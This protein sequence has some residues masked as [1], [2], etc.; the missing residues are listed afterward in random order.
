MALDWIPRDNVLKSHQIFGDEHFGT[1]P[2]CTMFEKKPLVNPDT[3]EVVDG[4]LQ[5]R[6]IDYGQLQTLNDMK[7][8]LLGWVYDVNF[9]PTLKRIK[10]RRILE[11]LIDF[12]PEDV[13]IGRVR[14]K[15]LG[16][17]DFRIARQASE[18]E[19]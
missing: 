1:E 5:G 17:V 8:C 6:R 19:N 10:Q 7:L 11:I 16:Y 2:P 12:L 13:D 18:K 14:E 9:T 4:L 3:G 15:I